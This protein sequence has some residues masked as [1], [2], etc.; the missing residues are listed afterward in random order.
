MQEQIASLMQSDQM[1]GNA[2][3]TGAFASFIGPMDVNSHV[4][5]QLK[6]LPQASKSSPNAIWLVYR[7]T[8]QEHEG[9]SSNCTVYQVT[10]E[11]GSNG[12][13]LPDSDG[14]GMNLAMC[15][16]LDP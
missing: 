15:A 8:E 3:G 4:K 12:L 6:A 9:M 16:K 14:L 5:S 13:T 11:H 7:S 1:A 2:P 10:K